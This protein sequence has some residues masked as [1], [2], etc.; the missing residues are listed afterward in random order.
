MTS[1]AR[2]S[3][4]HKGGG[5]AVEIETNKPNQANRKS[6]R[7]PRDVRNEQHQNFSTNPIDVV[8]G[9]LDS[10]VK[11][12]NGGWMARCPAHDDKRR[13]LAVAVG[14]AGQVIAN[15]FAGCTIAE[16]T[17][18]LGLE[19]HELY[20]KDRNDYTPQDRTYFS[21]AQL[22][23]ALETDSL[24]VMIA[25]SR[26]KA[27]EALPDEDLKFLSDAVV[28]IHE[29]RAYYSRGAQK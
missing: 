26:V 22:M 27:G 21:Y 13:S 15:C 25:A 2:R 3:P 17:G 5:D 1:F 10:V 24:V 23:E 14:R 29:A 20:V 4:P 6:N 12:H 18:A 8:L 19:L 7:F 28:R 9:R 16:I 11:R